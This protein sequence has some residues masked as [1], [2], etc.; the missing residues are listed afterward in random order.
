MG[1]LTLEESVYGMLDYW[2]IYTI[3]DLRQAMVNKKIG[4]TGDLYKS[5]K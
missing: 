2:A 3:K 5:F 4:Q 1:P